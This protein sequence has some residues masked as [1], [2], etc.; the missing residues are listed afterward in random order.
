MAALAQLGA[1]GLKAAGAAPAVAAILAEANI[2]FVAGR[3]HPP[4]AVAKC[5]N[6][7]SF[8]AATDAAVNA[9]FVE[10]AAAWVGSMRETSNLNMSGLTQLKMYDELGWSFPSLWTGQVPAHSSMSCMP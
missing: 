10:W 8:P 3:L 4:C 6:D 9:S 1:V 2:S 5:K 7:H